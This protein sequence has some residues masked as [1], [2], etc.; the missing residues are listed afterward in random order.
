MMEEVKINTEYI[1]LDQFLKYVG[2]A[3]TGGKGKQMIL[4]G[5]VK[6]NGNIELKR[7][8]KL[9]KGDTVIVDEKKFVIK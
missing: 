5:L 1:T 7:G 2:I 6:V 3:E 4:E 9:R 8:K